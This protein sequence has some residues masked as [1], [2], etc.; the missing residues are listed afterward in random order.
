MLPPDAFEKFFIVG[1]VYAGRMNRLEYHQTSP[2]P[3]AAGLPADNPSRAT[4]ANG[5][6]ERQQT[7]RNA[8]NAETPNRLAR[9]GKKAGSRPR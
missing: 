7:S 2:L 9:I 3:R 4:T 6:P 1:D 5:R 8:P